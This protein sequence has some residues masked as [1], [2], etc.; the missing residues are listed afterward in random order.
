MTED[1]A[2]LEI[3]VVELSYNEWLDVIYAIQTGTDPDLPPSDGVMALVDAL[4]Q[5]GL[6]N[7]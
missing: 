2:Q 1:L 5:Q 3:A 4:D 7:G 6:P